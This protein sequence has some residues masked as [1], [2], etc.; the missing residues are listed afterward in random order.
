M[1]DFSYT[2]NILY[3][4]I[5]M[6][7]HLQSA[8][9]KT[10]PGTTPILRALQASIITPCSF[11]LCGRRHVTY[12]RMLINSKSFHVYRSYNGLQYE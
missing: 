12:D 7:W 6:Y 3:D 1:I 4:F 10:K 5:I 8:T 9:C 11:Y 2:C